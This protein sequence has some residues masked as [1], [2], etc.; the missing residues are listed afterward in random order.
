MEWNQAKKDRYLDITEKLQAIQDRLISNDEKCK[1]EADYS[2]KPQVQAGFFE[3]ASSELEEP[4]PRPIS[5]RSQ[6]ELFAKMQE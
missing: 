4:H 1:T 2:K 3:E 6:E 5:H